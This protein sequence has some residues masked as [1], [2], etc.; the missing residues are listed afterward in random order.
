MP[1]TGFARRLRLSSDVLLDRHPSPTGTPII[2]NRLMCPGDFLRK[3]VNLL[4]DKWPD[5]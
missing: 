1:S 2:D 4:Y 5:V 3:I